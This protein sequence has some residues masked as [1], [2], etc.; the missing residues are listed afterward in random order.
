MGIS[1]ETYTGVASLIKSILMIN[2]SPISCYHAIIHLSLLLLKQWTV[3]I[4]L[5]RDLSSWNLQFN[6]IIHITPLIFQRMFQYSDVFLH[7]DVVRGR[8]NGEF[9]IIC[10]VFYFVLF[11]FLFFLKLR[12]LQKILGVF[13]NLGGPIV[14]YKF[15][16]AQPWFQQ[17]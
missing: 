13:I 3:S 7:V 12:L 17:C 16:T 10:F 15:T 6:Q 11:S 9:Q 4:F 8:Q 1:D 5:I 2:W 14:S